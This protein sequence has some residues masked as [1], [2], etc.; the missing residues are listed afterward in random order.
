MFK[1][2]K[3]IETSVYPNTIILWL[4]IAFNIIYGKDDNKKSAIYQQAS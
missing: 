1:K 3:T 2:K 4:V